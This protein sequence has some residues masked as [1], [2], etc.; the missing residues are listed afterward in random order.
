MPKKASNQRKNDNALMCRVRKELAKMSKA[1]GLGPMAAKV[2]LSE[3]LDAPPPAEQGPI[4][5]AR[6]SGLSIGDV[7]VNMS[8]GLDEPPPADQAVLTTQTPEPQESREE[9]LAELLTHEVQKNQNLESMNLQLRQDKEMMEAL[10]TKRLQEQR[11]THAQELE[12][13]HKHYQTMIQEA[14]A[15]HWD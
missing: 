2:G 3:E 13:M 6:T 9:I 10:C 5:R 4:T 8:E 14:S 12:E 11:E 1:S 7:K 15:N